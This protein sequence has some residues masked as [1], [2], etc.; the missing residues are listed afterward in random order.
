M[1]TLKIE[2][3]RL[4]TGV[5][6]FDKLIQGGIP[7]G[8]FVAVVGEPGTGKTIFSI[9]FIAEGIRQGDKNIY[10]TTEESKESI[11]KQ[12]AMFGFDF[13]K[14]IRDGKLVIID[15]LM[16][17]RDDPWS[18]AELDVETLVNKVIEAKRYLGYGRA[19]LVV[20]SMS[21]F[22]LDKPAMARKYSYFVKRVLYRW[23]FTALLI[24][25]YA[26]TT[27]LGFG[28]G[29]EHVADG[30]IRFRKS[31][32]RGELRRYVIIEKMRQTEHSLRMHEIEIRD[33]A[34]MR[35]KAPTV[36]RKEDTALPPSVA[37]RMLAAELQ[38]LLEIPN[39]EEES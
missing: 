13:E 29:I 16:G 2:I 23:D 17:K 36:Y 14:A 31:V 6:G 34:G 1:I 8:F 24:S 39:G 30:I 19:R 21:A 20:D 3:E 32:V 9:H 38:R 4:P 18:I 33:G 26:V 11:I 22:W 37:A 7:R 28:F 15:A 27:S 5:P 25:Q 12:A 35:V 10:V